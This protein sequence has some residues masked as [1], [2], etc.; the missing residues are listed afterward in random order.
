MFVFFLAKILNLVYL[1][2][3]ECLKKNLREISLY[4]T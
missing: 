3:L 4:V 1:T 2:F